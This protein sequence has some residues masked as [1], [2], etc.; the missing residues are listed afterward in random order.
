MGTMTT[1]L[2]GIAG[3]SPSSGHRNHEH[4]ARLGHRADARIGLRMA[5]GAKRDV[6]IQFLVAIARSDRRWHWH[7]L[8]FSLA[9]GWRWMSWP[10]KV[11]VNAVAM[12]FGFAAAT[13]VFFG[14]PA[15]AASGSD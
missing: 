9:E 11:P 10:A 1:L 2:T 15:Q 8:G 4:H 14:Y 13:G 3:V 5:I 6:L 12:A 7:R